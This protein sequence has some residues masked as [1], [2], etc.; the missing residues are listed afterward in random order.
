MTKASKWT[1]TVSWTV[2]T[3]STNY[4]DN[5]RPVR[6]IAIMEVGETSEAFHH[7]ISTRL[8][9]LSRVKLGR[10][11][12]NPLISQWGSP[13]H[14]WTKSHCQSKLKYCR[15]W[16]QYI[17]EFLFPGRLKIIWGSTFEQSPVLMARYILG[18]FPALSHSLQTSYSTPR[19]WP[20]CHSYLKFELFMVV[21]G[22]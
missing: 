8:P 1:S 11:R 5:A 21:D 18:S 20:R 14:P 9:S 22:R 6:Q 7:A 3:N 10:G 15:K 19:W 12:N 13:D 2:T 4:N 16:I 17:G